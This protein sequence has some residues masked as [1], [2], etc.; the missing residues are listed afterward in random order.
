[1]CCTH[2]WQNIKFQFNDTCFCTL[3]KE[4]WISYWV[5]LLLLFCVCVCFVPSKI[6]LLACLVRSW[7]EVSQMYFAER[8]IWTV[9]IR[10][11]LFKNECRKQN[12]SIFT[13]FIFE[14]RCSFYTPLIGSSY[15]DCFHPQS[16]HISQLNQISSNECLNILWTETIYLSRNNLYSLTALFAYILRNSCCL[17]DLH[18]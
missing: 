18:R 5:I 2:A 14:R 9:S 4:I 1:M 3:R 7:F 13:A 8:Q 6:R 16:V 17:C 11:F 10:L 15:F 12:I